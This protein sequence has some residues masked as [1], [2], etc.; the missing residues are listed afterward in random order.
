[1]V[2]HIFQSKKA[3]NRFAFTIDETGANLPIGEGEWERSGTAIPLG[4]T[5][6][7]TS[8]EIARQIEIDGYALVEGHS[9]AERH[10]PEGES[11]P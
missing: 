11:T 4:V 10:L 1:M 7:S 9:A 5:M 3:P 8:P 2:L 6:A